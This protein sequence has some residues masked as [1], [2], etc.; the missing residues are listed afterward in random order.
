[1][2]KH[3]AQD[4]KGVRDVYLDGVLVD[5]VV[6]ADTNRGRIT[7]CEYPFRVL[8]NGNVKLIHRRGTVQVVPR[9]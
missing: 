6:W 7:Q 9:G 1:M 2:A 4:G 8:P 5:H 3:S